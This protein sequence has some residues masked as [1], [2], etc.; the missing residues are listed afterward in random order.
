MLFLEAFNENYGFKLSPHLPDDVKEIL[1]NAPNLNGGLF[2]KSE[3][4]EV[5]F[6]I[7]DRLFER[8]LG[9]F[10]KY[11]FTIREDLPLDVEVAVD[12]KML[13]YVYESLSNV[14]EE[15]YERQ[16]L[17]I[18]YTPT[19][20][21]DFMCRRALV[22]Y[23]NNHIPQLGKKWMYHLLFD[24]DKTEVARQISKYNLWYTFE[25]VL[26]VLQW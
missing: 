17:G 12:P 2:R 14:A 5:K 20:E 7:S 21:V 25:E 8:I 13:G 4:D 9:F 26:T 24:E 11:N 3:L 22:E 23:I 18:F 1:S 15:I 10:E 19:V 6:H 16:D